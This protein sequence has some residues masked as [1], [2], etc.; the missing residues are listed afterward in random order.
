M[1][2]F[3]KTIHKFKGILIQLHVHAWY[4]IET[5][6]SPLESPRGRF[7]VSRRTDRRQNDLKTPQ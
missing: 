1:G 6:A 7:H 2:Y 5:R 3:P 4:D